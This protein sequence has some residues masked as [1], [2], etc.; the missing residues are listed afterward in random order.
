[1][2]EHYPRFLFSYRMDGSEW[3]FDLPARDFDDAQRRIAAIAM[4]GK[5]DGQLVGK[6]IP[7]WRGWWVPALVW[8]KNRGWA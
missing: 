2:T 3:S 8:L 7:A 1:M 5:V 6:P 4:T